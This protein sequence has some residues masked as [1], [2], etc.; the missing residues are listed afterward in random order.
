[1]LTEKT[2]SG[3]VTRKSYRGQ[4]SDVMKTFDF[5]GKTLASVMPDAG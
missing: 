3:E 5:S 2:S 4:V 1:V